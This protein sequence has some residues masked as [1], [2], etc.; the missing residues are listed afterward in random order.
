MTQWEEHS[1]CNRK[2]LSS[3]PRTPK[4]AAF[5]PLTLALWRD[6]NGTAG[7]CRSLLRFSERH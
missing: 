7:A 3:N 4:Q 5:V 2:D 6:R 1:L